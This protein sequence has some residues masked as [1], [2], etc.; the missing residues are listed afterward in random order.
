MLQRTISEE[1]LPNEMLLDGDLDEEEEEEK[2]VNEPKVAVPEEKSFKDASNQLTRQTSANGHD[3]FK[4]PPPTPE[5]PVRW[6]D[7]LWLILE[8]NRYWNPD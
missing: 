2:S 3:S 1:S 8:F 7:Y 4:T 6:W 5:R